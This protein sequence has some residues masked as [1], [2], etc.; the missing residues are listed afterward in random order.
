MMSREII[1]VQVLLSG[2]FKHDRTLLNKYH[3]TKF[4][5]NPFSFE[6]STHGIDIDLSS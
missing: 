1:V 5:K 4:D 2:F 3:K 6:K